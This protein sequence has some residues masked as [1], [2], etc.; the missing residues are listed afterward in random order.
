MDETEIPVKKRREDNAVPPVGHTGARVT[1][2][3]ASYHRV[4][5]REAPAT[6]SAHETRVG[7][8]IEP[9]SARQRKKRELA[10]LTRQGLYDPVQRR[11]ITYR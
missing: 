5:L 3:D 10:E 9:N 4:L 2:T 1:L 6:V 8:P 7:R 11:H